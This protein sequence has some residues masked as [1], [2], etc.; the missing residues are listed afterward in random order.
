MDFEDGMPVTLYKYRGFTDEHHKSFLFKQELF[1]TA[2][3]QFNDP[4]DCAVPIIYSP[5]ELSNRELVYQKYYSVIKRSQMNWTHEQI[6]AECIKLQEEGFLPD[7]DYMNGI[8]DVIIEQNQNN[9]GVLSLTMDPLNF[10]MWSHYAEKHCG[11]CIG[12]NTKKLYDTVMGAL[13]PVTY[14][15][16]IPFF[17]LIEDLAT[18][19]KRVFCTKGLFWEY[20]KEYR[21]I[22]HLAAKEKVRYNLEIINEVYFGVK[23]KRE[24]RQKIKAFVEENN[25]INCKIFEIIL[26]KGRFAL[27]SRQIL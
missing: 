24:D 10:L 14:T 16:K 13:S 22:K 21:I 4:L 1:L 8:N 26:S 25:M 20:E 5:D 3:A 15:E 6:H 12:F 27:E 19:F 18:F 17:P 9:Y 23:M 11:Y 7:E 2:P